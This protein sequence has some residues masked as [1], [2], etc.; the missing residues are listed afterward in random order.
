[1]IIIIILA[2]NLQMTK[3][4]FKKTILIIQFQWYKYKHIESAHSSK[5]S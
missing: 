4:A 3:Q 5:N 1:M 2:D